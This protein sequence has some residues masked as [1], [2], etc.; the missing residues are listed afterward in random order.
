M[1]L[2][3][4]VVGQPVIRCGLH[5]ADGVEQPVIE[6]LLAEAAVEA[7]DE[8][9]AVGLAGL[10]EQQLDLVLPGP[11][12]EGTENAD[13]SIFRLP[14][15]RESL[16]SIHS[17]PRAQ[18]DAFVSRK[19]AANHT[20]T[21]LLRDKLNGIQVDLDLDLVIDLFQCIGKPTLQP[22]PMH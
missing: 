16:R 21:G 5:L 14:A 9:V 8:R 11:A 15:L 20:E 13:A 6:H 10:D 12:D 2:V 7:L 3:F 19:R 17:L 18:R 4:I 22:P 1:R